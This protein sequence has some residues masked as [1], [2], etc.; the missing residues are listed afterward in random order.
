MRQWAVQYWETYG[1]VVNWISVKSILA[2]A[3][4][5]ALPRGSIDFVLAFTQ[6]DLDMYVLMELP[7]G[8]GM[9]RNIGELFL[10]SNTSFYGLKQASENWFDLMKVV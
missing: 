1:P 9:Y 6:S 8:M 2:I 7:L 4:I 3:N 10:D 5:H